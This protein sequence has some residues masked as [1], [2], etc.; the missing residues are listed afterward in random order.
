MIKRPENFNMQEQ[1]KGVNP[2]GHEFKRFKPQKSFFETIET[3]VESIDWKSEW[4]A[5]KEQKWDT[6]LGLL[7]I[8]GKP[9]AGTS[10]AAKLL[11][12]LYEASLYKAG[13]TIR[14][15]A[16]HSER[17]SGFIKRDPAIDHVVDQKIRNLTVSAVKGKPSIAEAQIGAAT[18]LETI[19]GLETSK[20]YPKGPIFRI[21][22]WA[23]KK[24]RVRRL[25][26]ASDDE[27]QNKLYDEIWKDTTDREKDDLSYWR[28]LYPNLIGS[29][30]P[31]EKNALDAKGNPIYN[32]PVFD[33]T[34]WGSPERSAYEVHKYLSEMGIVRP[35]TAMVADLPIFLGYK[36]EDNYQGGTSF[37]IDNP[38]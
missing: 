32:T 29:D 9:G 5:I 15:L 34:N 23:T 3:D 37:D 16:G 6:D 28:N 12:S 20:Q 26:Q 1:G 21:L 4:L 11:S 8:S 24:E 10:S 25:K 36:P 17:A 27:G 2:D 22:F 18:V 35:K 30:N 14:E 19:Q 31:L 13:D 33:N 7:V 38:F